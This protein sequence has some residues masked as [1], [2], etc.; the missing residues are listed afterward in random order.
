MNT[1]TIDL[2]GTILSDP[3]QETARHALAAAGP[4]QVT[5]HPALQQYQAGG[6][7]ML[8]RIIE[9]TAARP[10][11]DVAKI[12]SLID[13]YERWEAREAKKAFDAA[14]ADFVGE[15]VVIIK[16]KKVDF[17]SSRTNTR[18]HYKH[19]ELVD[20]IEAAGPALAKHGFSWSWIPKQSRE[21]VEITCVLKHRLGHSDSVTLGGPPDD[22]GNKNSIQQITSTITMLER[23]TLKAICGLAEKGD[24]ND[25]RGTR[26]P[27]EDH[28]GHGH[29]PG[30]PAEPGRRSASAKT[31]PAPAAKPKTDPATTKVNAGQVK[32][33]E[34]QVKVL[35]LAPAAVKK[36]CD[37][38]KLGGI[39]PDLTV[40][41]FEALKAELE[42]LRNA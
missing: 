15:A 20:V 24:D 6:G 13:V 41:Q 35:K 2:S 34:Q 25:G 11:M 16:R 36:L 9:S 27:N 4:G 38:L 32:Y 7:A 37:D 1:T 28:T 31:A 33:L 26:G 21:W 18:T 14:L 39:G 29:E 3:L 17:T 42:S 23:A 19:A 40:V 5:N 8:M 10:D 30:R 12:H 22:S